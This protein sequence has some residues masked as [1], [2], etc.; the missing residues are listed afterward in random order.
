M[1]MRSA[2]EKTKLNLT[3]IHVKYEEKM[4]D[5]QKG[6]FWYRI[7]LPKRNL[8][9]TLLSLKKNWTP[10]EE[11]KIQCFNIKGPKLFSISA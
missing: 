11:A 10:V 3:E 5:P 7:T 4:S 1:S 8:R 2:F 9:S 6:G